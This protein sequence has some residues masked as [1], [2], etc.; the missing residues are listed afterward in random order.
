MD[1]QSGDFI[2]V[3]FK[4][5]VLIVIFVIYDTFH[6]EPCDV[7]K[8]KPS[9]V[10][11][12]RDVLV[13]RFLNQLLVADR[14][15]IVSHFLV[16]VV[17]SIGLRYFAPSVHLFGPKVGQLAQNGQDVRLLHLGVLLSE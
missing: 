5:V 12:H 3:L 4:L 8:D 13:I 7:L 9:N 2:D 6:V 17:I 11:W 14:D 1:V 16:V 10:V 15:R